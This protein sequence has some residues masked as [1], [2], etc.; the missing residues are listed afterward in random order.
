M[1]DWGTKGIKPSDPK[2]NADKKPFSDIRYKKYENI[3]MLPINNVSSKI[4]LE[5]F[6]VL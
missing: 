5:F 3:V 4:D 6:M 1:I 2:P